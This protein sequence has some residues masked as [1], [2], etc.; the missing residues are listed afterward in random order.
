MLMMRLI[1]RWRRADGPTAFSQ[2]FIR[3]GLS[4]ANQISSYQWMPITSRRDNDNL[5]S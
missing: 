4:L 1:E 3:L 5:A 2:I